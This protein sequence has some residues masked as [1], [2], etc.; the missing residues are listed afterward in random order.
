MNIADNWR[1]ASRRWVS[2]AVS[3]VAMVAADAIADAP[4]ISRAGQNYTRAHTYALALLRFKASTSVCEADAG[5]T[6][7]QSMATIGIVYFSGYGH[8]KKQAEAVAAGARKVADA[9]VSVFYI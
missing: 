2:H 9:N 4:E 7:W 3:Q 1:Q 8:T 6:G 5:T